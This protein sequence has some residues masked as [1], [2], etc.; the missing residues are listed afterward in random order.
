MVGSEKYAWVILDR[1]ALFC[2]HC[3]HRDPPLFPMGLT[4]KR[5]DAFKLLTEAFE[6]EHQDCKETETS[7]SK[8]KWVRPEDWLHR[9]DTGISSETIYSVMTGRQ[10]RTTGYPLDASDFGRCYRLLA[11]FPDW[12]PRMQEVA[13]RFKEWGPL[14]REWDL[15]TQLYE[16]DLREDEEYRKAH[17][18]KSKPGACATYIAMQACLKEAGLR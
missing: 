15:L 5:M 6:E 4:K 8:R 11:L 10:V 9:H 18:G 7:P 17:K 13:D 14:V 1:D 12:R 16:Q 3:G 2:L